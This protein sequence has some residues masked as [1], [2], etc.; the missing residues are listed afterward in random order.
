[1]LAVDMRKTPESFRVTNHPGAPTL[2]ELRGCV[3]PVWEA[4]VDQQVRELAA[5]MN[6][7]VPNFEALAE[8]LG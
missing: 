6:V 7:G 5:E 4:S 2:S 3:W 8:V 1:M